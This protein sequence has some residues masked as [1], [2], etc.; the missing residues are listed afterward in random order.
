MSFEIIDN[1]GVIHSS[2]DREDM[3]SAFNAMIENKEYFEYFEDF[4]EA[5]NTYQCEWEGD[6]KLVKVLRAER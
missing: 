2:S 4:E 3:E 1:N 5:K 6:L